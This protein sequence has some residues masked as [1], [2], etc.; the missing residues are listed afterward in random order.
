MN[1]GTCVICESKGEYEFHEVDGC[2]GRVCPTCQKNI[3]KNGVR[4]AEKAAAQET[5]IYWVLNGFKE[6]R[7]WGET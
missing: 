2:I 3:A 6:V 1:K 7:E 4:Y 5:E